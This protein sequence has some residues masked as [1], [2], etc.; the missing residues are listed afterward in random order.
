[1]N[2]VYQEKV[3]TV[4]MKQNHIIVLDMCENNVGKMNTLN[5]KHCRFTQIEK[6]KSV[7]KCSPLFK[8]PKI[9]STCWSRQCKCNV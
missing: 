1:V 4:L 6:S 7:W 9:G 2:K 5:P 8:T 3:Y